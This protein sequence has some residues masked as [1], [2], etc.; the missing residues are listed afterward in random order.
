MTNIWT[1]GCFDIIHLG[2][3]SLFQY[4]KSLGYNLTVGI[5]SDQRIKKLKGENKPF[6]NQEYRLKFL[7]HIKYIDNLVVF[8]SDEELI[9]SLVKH[10]IDTI[11]IG[12]D[13]INKPVIG[14]EVV[15]RVI[16]F[17]KIPDLSSSIIY[18]SIRRS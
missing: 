13:Y 5:D 9:D 10:S 6:H 12:D 11:V 15:K 2:H 1:N 18:E 16:F 17:P 8:D 7:S 4:A 14:R 3:L